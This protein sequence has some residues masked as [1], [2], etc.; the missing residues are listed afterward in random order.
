M[1][2]ELAEE[3]YPDAIIPPNKKHRRQVLEHQMVM[4]HHLKRAI[5]PDETIH[6]K[7][8]NRSNND[9][10][11]LELWVSSHRYGQRVVDTVEWAIETLRRYAPNNLS[12]FAAQG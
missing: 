11:N 9:L 8:G 5:L 2:A 4:S 1:N 7:D 3:L 12:E 10:S 6:H